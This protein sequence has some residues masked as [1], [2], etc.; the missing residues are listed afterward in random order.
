MLVGHPKVTTNH[1]SEPAKVTITFAGRFV[2]WAIRS[3]TTMRLGA[4]SAYCLP[5]PMLVTARAVVELG[6]T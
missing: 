1:A 2:N 5:R 3:R 4:T 6:I